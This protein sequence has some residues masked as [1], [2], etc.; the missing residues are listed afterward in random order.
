MMPEWQYEKLDLNDTPRKTNEI[1]ILND[2]GQDGWEFGGDH[3]QQCGNPQ[4]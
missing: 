3:S 4:A 1:D 2:A